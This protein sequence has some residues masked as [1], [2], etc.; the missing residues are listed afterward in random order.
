MGHVFN[1][2]M[3]AKITPPPPPQKK[4]LWLVLHDTSLATLQV[5]NFVGG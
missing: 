1:A 5:K 2:T 4:M 3:P